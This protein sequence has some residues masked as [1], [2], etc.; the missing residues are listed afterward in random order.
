MAEGRMYT[1]IVIALSL[2]MLAAF[3][4]LAGGLW[5][6]FK[7]RNARQALLM[8]L[9]AAVFFANVLIWTV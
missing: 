7:R 9:A 3:T 2:A 1:L 4:L 5:L 6:L 8:L